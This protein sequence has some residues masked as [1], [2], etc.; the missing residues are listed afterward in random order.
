MNGRTAVAEDSGTM[1]PYLAQPVTRAAVVL[2]R[3]AGLLAWFW[4]SAWSCSPPT[5]PA[6]RCSLDIG[7]GRV[8]APVVLCVLP[9]AR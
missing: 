5:W 8:A 2:D 4:S 1:E 3:P 7:T 6:M 9:G